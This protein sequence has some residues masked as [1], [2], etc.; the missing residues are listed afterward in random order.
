MPLSIEFQYALSDRYDSYFNVEHLAI[1]Y[2]SGT[3]ANDL[4]IRAVSAGK[5]KVIKKMTAIIMEIGLL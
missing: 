4:K 2:C 3:V 5:V 1:D